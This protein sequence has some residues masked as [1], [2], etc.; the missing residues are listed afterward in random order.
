MKNKSNYVTPEAEFLENY[1]LAF[2]RLL[3]KYNHMVFVSIFIKVYPWLLWR[4]YHMKQWIAKLSLF[5]WTR[6][7]LASKLYL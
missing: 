5:C 2:L 3:W 1:S 6:I 4:K 7:L